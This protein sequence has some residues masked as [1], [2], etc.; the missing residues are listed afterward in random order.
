MSLPGRK[1]YI[2]IYP[3]Y[4]PKVHKCHLRQYVLFVH[5]QSDSKEILACEKYQ[6]GI[7]KNPDGILRLCCCSVTNSSM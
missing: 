4:F 3:A 1:V 5:L 2:Y 6:L 7:F